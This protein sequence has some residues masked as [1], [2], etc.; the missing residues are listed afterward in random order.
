MDKTEHRFP[1]IKPCETSL[2]SK[3]IPVNH[4]CLIYQGVVNSEI[5]FQIVIAPNMIPKTP[6]LI[7]NI[8]KFFR[9]GIIL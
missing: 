9:S 6:K 3:K 1:S 8:K 5:E 2:T 4:L 7:A